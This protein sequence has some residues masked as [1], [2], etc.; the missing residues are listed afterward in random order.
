MREVVGLADRRP[1]AGARTRA[2]V[3]AKLVP[4]AV[5]DA[6]R[7]AGTDPDIAA[8]VAGLTNV[9]ADDVARSVAERSTATR[10]A[11]AT[12]VAGRCAPEHPSGGIRDADLGGVRTAA[13]AAGDS[14]GA[15]AQTVSAAAAGHDRANHDNQ[16][17]HT[18]TIQS[19]HS[20]SERE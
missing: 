13:S 4:A 3:G 18:S 16:H 1:A 8:G 12:A 2:L 5:R 9:R 19:S 17:S 14:A 11:V 20:T 15:F 10:R 6:A 7:C